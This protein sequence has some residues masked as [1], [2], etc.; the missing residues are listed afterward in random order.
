M[1]IPLDRGTP[2]ERSMNEQRRRQN[3]VIQRLN[4]MLLTTKIKRIRLIKER[5][6]PEEER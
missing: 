3:K 6:K 4:D 5:N 2:A 1:L